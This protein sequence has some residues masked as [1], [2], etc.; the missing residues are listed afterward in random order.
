MK[1]SVNRE[2]HGNIIASFEAENEQEAKKMMDDYINN[3]TEEAFIDALELVEVNRSI[4][5]L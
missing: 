4:E 1:Y 5:E 3:L 2:F